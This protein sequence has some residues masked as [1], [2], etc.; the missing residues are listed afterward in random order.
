VQL[1]ATIYL[2]S[3]CPPATACIVSITPYVADTLHE[4]GVHLAK[5]GYVFVA[6]DSRGRGNSEGQFRP[7]IQE[8]ADGYDVVEWLA[9]QPYCNGK[10]AMRGGSYLGYVQWATAKEFPPHL[11][12][13]VPAAAPLPGVDFPMRSNIAYPYLIAWL[14]L[15]A[16]HTSQ[17]NLLGDRTFW[18]Q[19]YRNWHQSGRAFRCLNGLV[20]Q[21]SPAFEEWLAHPR[22]DEYWDAYNPTAPQ[23]ANIQIPILTIT[24]SYDDDQPGA[25]EHHR[26][27]IRNAGPHGHCRHYLIIGPWDHAGT[28]IPKLQVGGVTFGRASLLDLQQL[29]IDWYG[30]VMGELPKPRFLQKRVA[31]YVTGLEQWHY[32]DSLEEVT[33]HSQSYFLGS[34]TNASDPFSSGF[35]T[36]ESATGAASS[37]A[38]TYDPRNTHGPEV[39]A[40]SRTDP[41]SLVDQSVLFALRGCA[42][43]YHSAPFDRDTE[44]SGFFS[45]SAWISIDTPDTDL[46][47]SVHEIATD[48][49]SIRLSSDALR[50]RYREDIRDPKLI[51]SSEAM[52]YEFRGFTFIS[53]QVKKGHRLRLVI[54][55]FGRLVEASFTQKNY[56][57]GGVV[58]DESIAD[59]RPVTV[60]LFHDPSHP[61]VLSVPMGR[62]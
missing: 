33:D 31:Y 34:D 10:V 38:Y 37:D 45:L 14:T 13:I 35:L 27:H 32:A 16:G 39:D 53:R 1:A 44:I 36:L 62:G 29:H 58:A 9:R 20:N 56:N 40:E 61:S 42:L 11:K 3:N 59:A 17:G 52:L 25:L 57:S 28:R 55:P 6:V 18:S 19:L 4:V 8:A 47:V 50:A 51:A 2:P 26:R 48:G 49:A 21:P 30:W 5:H 7:L 12:T 43:F 23:Y 15:T 24:G 41:G 54:A 60:I 22:P 46:Y